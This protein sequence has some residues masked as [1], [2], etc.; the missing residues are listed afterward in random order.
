MHLHLTPEEEQ[1]LIFGPEKGLSGGCACNEQPVEVHNFNE[2]SP[3]Q[4]AI[5]KKYFNMRPD[6]LQTLK[7][8]SLLTQI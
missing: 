8:E 7:N 1:N 5:S 6:D 3:A 4:M 2:I